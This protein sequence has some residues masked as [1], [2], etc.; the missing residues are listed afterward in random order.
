MKHLEVLVLTE[1]T[2]VPKILNW[3]VS[4]VNTI[5]TAIEKLQQ[6]PY[7]VVAVSKAIDAVE[8]RKLIQ[9]L[10]IITSDTILVKYNSD[11][12]LEEVVKTAYWSKNKPNAKRKVL[13]NSF[14]IKLA[15]SIQFNY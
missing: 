15:N 7:K 3:K 12:S 5:E 10:P 11:K 13:D 8:I 1:K 9:L 2:T 6:K 14:E 4:I